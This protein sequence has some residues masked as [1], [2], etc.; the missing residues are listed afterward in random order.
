MMI[1]VERESPNNIHQTVSPTALWGKDGLDFIWPELSTALFFWRLFIEALWGACAYNR[2]GLRHAYPDST[3]CHGF[4][5]R[6]PV[7]DERVKG[8][9]GG[10]LGTGVH[11]EGLPQSEV[12]LLRIIPLNQVLGIRMACPS[13]HLGTGWSSVR[14]S[15][16][17]R[18]AQPETSQEVRTQRDRVLSGVGW[19]GGGLLG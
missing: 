4:G 6:V 18:K 2:M 12:Q 11:T 15:W 8:R 19:S 13:A 3:P 10:I 5:G 14:V 17:H 7:A 1:E 9:K 16:W